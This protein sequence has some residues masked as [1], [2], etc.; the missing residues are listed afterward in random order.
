MMFVQTMH[1]R[2]GAPGKAGINL[3]A[4]ETRICMRAR[5]QYVHVYERDVRDVRDVT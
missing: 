5:E 2:R 3:K 1:A 4:R